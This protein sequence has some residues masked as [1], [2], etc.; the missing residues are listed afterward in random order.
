[1]ADERRQSWELRHTDARPAAAPSPFVVAAL[2]NVGRW[3]PRPWPLRALDVACGS[4]RHAI[5]LAARGYRVTAVDWAHAAVAGVVA[6]ARERRLAVDCLVADV[7]QWPLPRARY[8]VI[9]AADFLERALFSA[10][11]AAVAPGGLLIIET[12]LRGH[13]RFGRPSNPDFLLRS[14]ELRDV[15]ADWTI[16]DEYEGE[17]TTASGARA[18]RAGIVA[19]RPHVDTPEPFGSAPRA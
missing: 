13:E 9:V 5:L 2:A 19:E 3:E 1:M 16:R 7:T 10:L 18:V 11:R 17:T 6:A 8:D 14:G 15:V 4:G 12:F